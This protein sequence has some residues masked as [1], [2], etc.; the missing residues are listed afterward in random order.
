MAFKLPAVDNAS[1]SL[2]DVESKGQS[3]KVRVGRL[4][5]KARADF[6]NLY[7]VR[8]SDADP[9]TIADAKAKLHQDLLDRVNGWDGVLGSDG[10]PVPFSKDV[11]DAWL[12]ADRD[13]YWAVVESLET[14]FT[15][16]PS[17]AHVTAVA[18]VAEARELKK[19]E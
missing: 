4:S 13:V 17:L 8:F 2:I 15:A 5:L 19:D 14:F 18:E 12:V 10:K 11:F 1:H 6:E 3:F 16:R 7:H 9:A